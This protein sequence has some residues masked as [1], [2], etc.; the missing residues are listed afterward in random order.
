MKL[1]FMLYQL[2]FLKDS[3]NSNFMQYMMTDEQITEWLKLF[4]QYN[5]F[6]SYE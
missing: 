6:K 1:W 3:F 5:N 4:S 2:G